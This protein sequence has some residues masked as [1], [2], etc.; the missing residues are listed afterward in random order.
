MVNCLKMIKDRFEAESVLEIS[1]YQGGR[2]G[3]WWVQ[4]ILHIILNGTFTNG[5]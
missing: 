1:E 2:K 4:K 5:E 3:W